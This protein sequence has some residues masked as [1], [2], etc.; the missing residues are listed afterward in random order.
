METKSKLVKNSIKCNTC[1]DVLVSKHGHDFVK[2]TCGNVFA[3]GGLNYCRR[4]WL[5]GEKDGPRGYTEL[6]EYMD[7][8]AEIW[9]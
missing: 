4:G 3:D 1:G 8:P 5:D 2:C 9:T 7:E 6:S